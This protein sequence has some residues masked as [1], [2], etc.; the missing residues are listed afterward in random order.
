[1]LKKRGPPSGRSAKTQR[2]QSKTSPGEDVLQLGEDTT[3]MPNTHAATLGVPPT[4]SYSVTSQR[5]STASSDGLVVAATDPLPSLAVSPSTTSYLQSPDD[6]AATNPVP[7]LVFI[8]EDPSLYVNGELDATECTPPSLPIGSPS[9]NDSSNL[10]T[11]KRERDL[12][13]VAEAIDVWPRKIGQDSLL[14]WLDVYFQELHPTVPVLSRPMIYQEM[15]LQTHHHDPQFGAMLLALCAFAMTQPVQSH[16]EVSTPSRSIQARL[17]LEESLKMRMTVDF[18]EIPNI[19]MV[20]TS[21]FIFAFLFG[22]G[23]H[24]AANHRLREAVDLALS[25][26]MDKPQA[27]DSL[28]PETRDQ[29]LRTYLHMGRFYQQFTD[30][31]HRTFALQKRYTIESR[32]SPTANACFIRAFGSFTSYSAHR[33]KTN[34][35]GMISLLYLMEAYN[36]IDES[37]VGCWA[38]YCKYSYGHCEDFDRRLALRMFRAQERAREDWLAGSI[39]SE[40]ST[41]LPSVHQLLESQQVDIVVTHFWLLN[42]IWE[43]RMS[44][45]L[46]RDDSEHRELRLDF[47]YHVAYKFGTSCHAMNL[48]ALEFHGVGIVEKIVDITMGLIKALNSSTQLSLDSS[49]TDY[50]PLTDKTTVPGPSVRL[51]LGNLH[52]IVQNLRGGSHD[53]VSRLTMALEAVPGYSGAAEPHHSVA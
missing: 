23:Q 5:M 2:R 20:L 28:D 21:F 13:P 51:V 38:G 32:G 6:N 25:M 1:M 52:Q 49:L 9:S 31:L 4:A 34:S 27:Y 26:D 14:P 24:R 45:G 39:S 19:Y 10:V 40:P 15:H 22:S 16:E 11:V 12:S 42:K 35:M 3:S 7:S 41:P 36:A 30:S 48:H 44:H 33:D 8:H 47:A 43:L 50:D 46:L 18:G 29:W 37:V 53:Y 17:F